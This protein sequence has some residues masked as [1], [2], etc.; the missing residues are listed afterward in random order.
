MKIDE[1]R[2]WDEQRPPGSYFI[3]S[4]AKGRDVRFF[5]TQVYTVREAMAAVEAGLEVTYVAHPSLTDID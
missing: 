1:I 4:D 3:V 5:G 2:S